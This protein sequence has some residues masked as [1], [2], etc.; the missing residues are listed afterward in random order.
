MRKG[1]KRCFDI[2][3]DDSE[4]VCSGAMQR[5]TRK[6]NYYQGKNSLKLLR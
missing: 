2:W 1:S 3:G 5:Y 4:E 6:K